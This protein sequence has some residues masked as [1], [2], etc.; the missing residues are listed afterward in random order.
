MAQIYISLG[1]NIEREYHIKHGIIS[2]AN[3]FDIAIEAMQLSSLFESEAIGFDSDNFYNMVIGLECDISV[4][5]VASM[6][7]KIEIA[8]GRTHQDKK[9]SPRTLDL[10]L[11]LYDDLIIDKPAQ[12]PREEICY[13]AFVLWPLSELAP[14]V[15][16]PVLQQ[17]Y[18]ELWQ[19][20]DKSSQQ[21]HIVA[22]CW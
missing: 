6:L 3:A 12:L 19:N 14:K 11:L 7:K 17:S 2:I 13:N 9:F 22:S 5:E 10:D 15:L 8:H 21:L 4:E 16:H 18:Q 20:Y 1:S